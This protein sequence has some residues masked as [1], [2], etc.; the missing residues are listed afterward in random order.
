MLN[1]SN[2]WIGNRLI[3]NIKR[4]MFLNDSNIL[5]EHK[6]AVFIFMSPN[7]ISKLEKDLINLKQNL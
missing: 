7:D 2:G 5:N 4:L 6:D 3:I 1:P